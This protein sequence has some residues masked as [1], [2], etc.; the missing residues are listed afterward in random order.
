MFSEI[1]LRRARRDGLLE[2]RAEGHAEGRA[3]GLAEGREEGL[4]EGLARGQAE[5]RALLL[6]DLLDL[7]FPDV[8]AELRARVRA[9]DPQ[10]LAAWTRRM[11]SASTLA[12][13]FDAEGPVP[14][15]EGGPNGVP[16]RRDPRDDR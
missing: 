6:L 14:A 8:P 1:F 12:G 2:G 9:A 15:G 10:E 7:R 5:G 13:V 4:A 3:E 16:L 11:F